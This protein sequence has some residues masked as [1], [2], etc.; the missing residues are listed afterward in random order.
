M[1]RARDLADSA[2]KDIAGTLTLDGLTVDG[3]VGIGTSSP[4]ADLHVNSGASN[5]AGLFE[6]TDA[7]AT[8]TLIDNGTTGGSAA[9]HGLNTVG[10][11]L[12]I[13]AVDN[14]SF[15]TG[16]AG[17]EAMR[18]VSTGNV[19]IGTAAPNGLVELKA[20]NG[21]GT[22]SIV[23][24]VNSVDAGNK[25]AFFAADRSDTDEEMAYIQPLL[26]SNSGGAGNVQEGHLTFG[27]FGTERMRIASNGFVGIGDSDPGVIVEVVYSDSTLY[28]DD[29]NAA[30]DCALRIHNNSNTTGAYSGIKL[31]SN[32]NNG[33][34]GQWMI[35]SVSTGTNYDN[36]LVFHTRTSSSAYAERMRIDTS[37]NF[38]IGKTAADVSAEGFE[39]RSSGNI[40]ARTAEGPVLDLR[41]GA[42]STSELIA[43]FRDDN[44]GMI[45]LGESGGAGYIEGRTGDTGLK[46]EGAHIRP[47]DNQTDAD[48]AV[49]LG[50]ASFRFDDIFATNATINTSDRNEKQQ[51]AAL[52]DTEITAA[53]AISK[54]FKNFKWNDRVT[55]KGD[56]ARTH[57]GIIAQEVEQAMTDAGL[58]AN[59][60]A[61]FISSTWWETQTDVPA[62]AAVAEVTETTTDEDGNE[63]VT[64]VTEAVEARDA[65]TRTDTYETAEEAPEGATERNRKGI[66]YTELLAFIGAATEQ[67]LT[68]IELRL[69]ALEAE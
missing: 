65:Y 69:A 41:R 4:A 54:L 55:E 2:D 16:G 62:V 66:R 11:Q 36:N 39:A 63:V 26:V 43:T 51:I 60:Y 5:L 31:H 52:T 23:S 50:N 13:R 18:I 28:D 48:N 53:K 64:V 35:G 38:M 67:R 19:G 1:T 24:T 59:N 45:K 22:L 20:G 40:H 30:T 27:T 8:I 61:F 21:S 3:N 29:A 68:S 46:F 33:T 14:L 12:E 17:S 9:E 57:T 7:G 32:N 15:E 56:A 58:S 6:S 25:I 47:R 34:V 49:D 42:S 37:G 10:N 44:T